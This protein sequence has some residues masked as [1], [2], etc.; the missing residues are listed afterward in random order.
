MSQLA[1]TSYAPA[2]RSGRVPRPLVA[3]A[4]G[5]GG[6]LVVFVSLL[7]GYGWL[8]VLRGVGWFATGPRVGDSLPLLQLAAFDGQP[9]LRVVVAWVL[10]GLI[11]GVALMRVR[12]VRRAGLAGGLSLVLL[13]VASQA[14]YALARNL[15]FSHVI[16][17]RRP[18]F[19][20]LLEGL[21]FAAACA[22]PRP[23]F[24]S[25]WAGR[26]PL[27]G[28]VHRAGNLALRGGQHR[29]AAEHDGDGHEV[30]ADGQRAGA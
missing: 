3:A 20:P 18:G 21:L 1:P 5:A 9:L 23:I 10:A 7:S 24:G 8:Y 22:L 25:Q 30:R 27:L 2:Q 28:G 14:A 11:A 4:A 12:P 29:N 15:R 26:R 19:G 17:S 6:A 16:F 13:L